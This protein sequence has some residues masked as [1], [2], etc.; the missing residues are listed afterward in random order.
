MVRAADVAL[1]PLAWTRPLRKAATSPIRRILLLRLERIGDLLMTIDAI[2]LA[3]A[4]WLRRGDR[5][6]G[7]IGTRRSPA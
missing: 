2:A 4:T 5:S 7:G 6:R 3:R 1:R